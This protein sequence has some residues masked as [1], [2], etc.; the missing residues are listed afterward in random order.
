MENMNGESNFLPGDAG[1]V[2]HAVASHG[3]VVVV[4]VGE[5]DVILLAAADGGGQEQEEP[6]HRPIG[7][8]HLHRANVLFPPS[9]RFDSSVFSRSLPLSF[10]SSK[11]QIIETIHH[12]F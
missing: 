10:L 2:F 12:T 4:V 9:S 5:V 1:P 8:C 6:P 11:E 3:V 7:S